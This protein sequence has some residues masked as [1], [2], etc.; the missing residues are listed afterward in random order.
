MLATLGRW[1]VLAVLIVVVARALHALSTVFSGHIGMGAA[2]A[3]L[4]VV[5][6]AGQALRERVIE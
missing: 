4:L 3:L 1:V 2:T 5:V 6:Y